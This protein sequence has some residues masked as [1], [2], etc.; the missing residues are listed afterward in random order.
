[1]DGP[2]S[3]VAPDGHTLPPEVDVDVD[4]SPPASW[5]SRCRL[6][7]LP[8]VVARDCL[9][10]KG[11]AAAVDAR[12]PLLR[13]LTEDPGGCEPL[14]RDRTSPADPAYWATL[15]D[16]LGRDSGTPSTS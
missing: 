13:A 16:S 7:D 3:L 5:Q 8:L 4:T 2:L 1:M 15:T 12:S 6:A 10:S 11:L 14:V 9:R